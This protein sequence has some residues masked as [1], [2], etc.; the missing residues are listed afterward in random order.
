MKKTLSIA[1]AQRLAE[2]ALIAAGTAPEN[3]RP[4]ARALVAAEASGQPGHGLSRIPSYVEQV[5]TSKVRGGA[6]PSAEL[7]KPGVLRIDAGFGFAYPAIEL[8]L[9]KL[10]AM[11]RANGVALAAIG[12]SHHFGQGG[13]HCERLAENGLVAMIFGNAPKAVAPWG[14]SRALFGTN[15]ICFAAPGP[16]GMPPLVIDFAVSRVAKGKIMAAERTGKSIPE[17]WALDEK[18]Q[19]TTNAADAMKGTMIPIGEAKGAALAMMIEVLS[20]ALVGAHFGFEASGLFDGK[21]EPPNLSQTILA[22]DPGVTSNEAYWQ[23]IAVLFEEIEQTDGARM[24]GSRRLE[25][26]EAATRAGLSVPAE[27]YRDLLL[28]A[29]ERS[30]ETGI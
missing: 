13:A 18:G 8:A 2:A 20:A 5:R 24:P 15:P 30:E 28:L 9:E 6:V 21:G 17:G 16:E 10:P 27:M 29:G 14:G 3:A 4:V 1:E 26:R 25:A 12:R 23:R 22:I 7:V 19:P 11:A